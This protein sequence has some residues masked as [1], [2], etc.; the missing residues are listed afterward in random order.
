MDYGAYLGVAAAA[1]ALAGALLRA[2]R[3]EG[4]VRHSE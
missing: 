2:R 1:A 4:H 3:P